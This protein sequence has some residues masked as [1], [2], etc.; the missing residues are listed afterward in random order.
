MT[1]VQTPD[2]LAAS[3][4]CIK[5]NFNIGPMTDLT[6][7]GIRLDTRQRQ[8]Y[9]L[10]TDGDS[11]EAVRCA[12][13]CVL[14]FHHIV[15]HKLYVI[16]RT[17]LYE[18][19]KQ[20]AQGTTCSSD[21]RKSVKV[22]LFPVFP[23][24]ETALFYRKVTGVGLLYPAITTALRCRWAWSLGGMILTRPNLNVA[25]S[26]TLSITNRKNVDSY[27]VHYRLRRD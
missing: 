15:Y 18:L 27:S 3:T 9:Q 17:N 24:S 12:D 14:A 2:N 22:L 13:G 1:Q 10:L 8:A 11:R 21:V 19:T 26:A 4:S 16:W 6:V 25:P 20:R 23:I 5:W 7:S